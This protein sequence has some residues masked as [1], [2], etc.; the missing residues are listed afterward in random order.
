[1]RATA[2]PSSR[3]EATR[4]HRRNQADGAE[5]DSPSWCINLGGVEL[6]RN[7]FVIAGKGTREPR[8]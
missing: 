4:A 8:A 5:I 2:Q 7:G 3:Q 1:L 6:D